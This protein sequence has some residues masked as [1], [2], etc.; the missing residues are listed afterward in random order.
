MSLGHF[1]ESSILNSP[2][3]L[4]KKKILVLLFWLS[5]LSMLSSQSSVFGCWIFCIHLLGLLS[6]PMFSISFSFLPS[7][8]KQTRRYL[9]IL[10]W[11][12]ILDAIFNLIWYYCNLMSMKLRLCYNRGLLSKLLLSCIFY[13][14]PVTLAFPLICSPFFHL[15]FWHRKFFNNILQALMRHLFRS[16]K[17]LALYGL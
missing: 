4:G 2:L 15:C 12:S 11:N 17:S 7:S 9:P 10:H 13:L 16:H 14:V 6:F 5:L 1:V 3:T 8:R